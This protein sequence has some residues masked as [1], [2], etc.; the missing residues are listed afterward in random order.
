METIL[1]KLV[2]ESETLNS[3]CKTKEEDTKIPFYKMMTELYSNLL[4]NL[5]TYTGKMV[6]NGLRHLSFD[7]ELPENFSNSITNDIVNMFANSFEFRHLNIGTFGVSFDYLHVHD[8]TAHVYV[9]VYDKIRKP[10][11]TTQFLENLKNG[12]NSYNSFSA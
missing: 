12:I 2:I 7:L 11:V 8:K 5:G 10:Q 6:N 3:I 1:N 9:W 4:N